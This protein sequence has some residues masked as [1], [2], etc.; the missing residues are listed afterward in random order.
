MLI[1]GRAIVGL[2]VG[3]SMSTVPV[4]LTEMAPTELRGSLG[5]LNQ[6]MIT[7][8]ILAAYLV[9]YAFADMGAWRWMLGLAVVPSLILLIGV[10]FMPESPRWLLEN[11][12]EKAARDVM[13]I[14][15]NPDAIDAEIKEMKEIASQS[16]STFSVIKSPWL[17]PT[18]I[19]GCIFAIFN[20][21]SESTQLFSMPQRFYKSRSRWLCFNYRY[22]WYWCGKRISNDFGIIYC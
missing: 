2:A 12:S 20:N 14:T 6:L 7:I 16:E 4:Y 5:S 1:I 19:I 15:Y 18:L 11:R 10:A 9:N 13:K 3:G 8:G 21:L 22:S 17:R